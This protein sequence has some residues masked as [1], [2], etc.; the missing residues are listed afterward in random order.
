MLVDDVS[1]CRGG[2]YGLFAELT[3][4]EVELCIDDQ[5]KAGQEGMDDEMW[6]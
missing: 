1:S 6:V 5:I 2:D 3:D 4:Q